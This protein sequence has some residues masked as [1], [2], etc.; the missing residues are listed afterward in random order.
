MCSYTPSLLEMRQ[1]RRILKLTSALLS[2][3]AM[4]LKHYNLKA[5]AVDIFSSVGE[6]PLH[7][8]AFPASLS[9]RE[10]YSD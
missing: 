8:C 4:K 3:R 6:L 7:K 10:E 2:R 5:P 9:I 1:R